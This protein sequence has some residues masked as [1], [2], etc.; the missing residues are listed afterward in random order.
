[1]S[2]QSTL[3]Q[4]ETQ[5]TL[6]PETRYKYAYQHCH[7]KTFHW[8]L[9][10][11]SDTNHFEQPHEIIIIIII[12]SLFNEDNIFSKYA[13]LTYGPLKSKNTNST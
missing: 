13:N 12:M 10:N 7:E 5:A 8:E 11:R 1:M 6:L 2:Y 4:S 3:Q 9:M